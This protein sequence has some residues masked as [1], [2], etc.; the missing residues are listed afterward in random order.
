MNRRVADGRGRYELTRQV[1]CSAGKRNTQEGGLGACLAN[2]HVG[3]A[4]RHEAR[5]VLWDRRLY[6]YSS[7]HSCLA[8]EGLGATG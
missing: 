3:T 7:L 5:V 2:Q 1:S 4:R 8:S 6:N